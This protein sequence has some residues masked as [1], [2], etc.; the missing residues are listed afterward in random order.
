MVAFLGVSCQ[1]NTSETDN[2]TSNLHGPI[3]KKTQDT[4]ANES[5]L[6]YVYETFELASDS[7]FPIDSVNKLDS[8][9]MDYATYR[10]NYPKFNQKNIQDFV[11]KS[12]LGEE[13][14]TP[15]QAAHQFIDEY[16]NFKKSY[17]SP[18]P[19]VHKSENK[20]MHLTDA[21]LGLKID[22]YHYTGG[23]HGNYYTL[24]KHFQLQ[25]N[26]EFAMEDLIKTSAFDAFLQVAEQHFWENE[27]ALNQDLREDLYFFEND[28][29]SLPNNFSF[30]S[31]S[32]LFLYNIYEIKPYVFGQTA[33]KI[34]YQEIESFL[35]DKALRII[36]SIKEK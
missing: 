22:N 35:T 36:A 29:F 1:T 28:V 10:I 8:T 3:V 17:F 30:E 26:S 12:Q 11:L 31:D 9:Q 21:Y 14:L 6:D 34:P 15:E 18:S 19:W 20:V 13:S 27:R 32:L 2:D 25:D 23:A 4:N 24:Y 16:E 7:T 5:R 33:F